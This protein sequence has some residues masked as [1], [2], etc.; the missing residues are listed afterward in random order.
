MKNKYQELFSILED[1]FFAHPHRHPNFKWNDILSRLQESPKKCE[2]LLKMEE[3]G[4]EP[5][6]IGLADETGQILYCDC[7]AESPKVRRSFCYDKAAKEKRKENK[8]VSSAE[9][10]AKE[11][12]IEIL[13]EDEYRLLQELGPF[14]QKTSSWLKTPE[15]IRKLGGAIFGDYRFGTVFIYHNSA[16]SY[17]ASR[18]F[19]G[20][21]RV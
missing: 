13:T 3:S 7:A 5:D 11:M 9:E 19:R 18:G 2:S 1:R 8:P 15:Q 14:D 21:L 16:E 6:V 17:Y 12:G 20:I 10:A 4:G